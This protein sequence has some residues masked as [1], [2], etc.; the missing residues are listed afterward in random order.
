MPA[1]ESNKG[2]EA[3]YST[4][5]SNNSEL[6]ISSIV[7]YIIIL[8]GSIFSLILINLNLLSITMHFIILKSCSISSFMF[9]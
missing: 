1:P 6:N 5:V 9:L 7:H 2:E 4:K 3:T 8:S